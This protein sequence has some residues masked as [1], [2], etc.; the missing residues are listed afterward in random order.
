[1]A[2]WPR[3]YTQRVLP[4]VVLGMAPLKLV[5]QAAYL[6]HIINSNL[7]DDSDLYKQIKKTLHD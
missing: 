2:F 7:K 3:L 4:L 5:D 1:M 6:G